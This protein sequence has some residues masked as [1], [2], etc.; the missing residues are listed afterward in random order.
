MSKQ[1][2]ELFIYYINSK[3]SYI[4]KRYLQKLEMYFRLG[5]IFSTQDRNTLIS[6]LI[7]KAYGTEKDIIRWAINVLAFITSYKDDEAIACIKKISSAVDVDPDILI[8]CI[9]AICR[10]TKNRNSNII[11]IPSDIDIDPKLIE[12]C[13]WQSGR[14]IPAIQGNNRLNHEK[15]AD[16]TLKTALIN[17]GMEKLPENY[18]SQYQNSDIIGDISTSENKI[19]KQYSIWAALEN[20]NLGI[21]NIK[22]DPNSIESLDDNVKIWIVRLLCKH[23]KTIDNFYDIIADYAMVS[24]SDDMRLNLSIGLIDK[25]IEKMPK[26][27]IRWSLNENVHEISLNILKHISFFHQ[28][29]PSYNDH[30]DSQFLLYRKDSQER[31][32][33]LSGCKGTSLWSTLRTK[34]VK[35]NDGFLGK[36]PSSESDKS[37]TINNNNFFNSPIQ[38]GAFSAQGSAANL[39][40]VNN[41]I[42]NN[43]DKIS[44]ALD[45]SKKIIE[46]L[47]LEDDKKEIILNNIDKAKKENN[48]EKRIALIERVLGLLP[49]AS[50]AATALND[51][52]KTFL[53][54]FTLG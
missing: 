21:D 33:I 3:E 30:I 11:K 41:K 18:F 54:D 49:A 14:N 35:E 9:S 19:I 28:K 12:L 17:L 6:S 43:T 2:S 51:I 20:K 44:E 7:V 8:S 22:V 13:R 34:E 32:T 29:S 40:E 52:I 27:M 15:C 10:I 38:A 47:E 5:Y 53:T 37:M 31:E 45:S 36:L 16:L 48:S 42:Q 4:V 46:T 39:A 23:Q 26:D 1:E 24:P 50:G 25:F